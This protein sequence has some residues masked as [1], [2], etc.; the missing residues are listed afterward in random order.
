MLH[1][2][3]IGKKKPAN[4]DIYALSPHVSTQMEVEFKQRWM[5]KRVGDLQAQGMTA[6]AAR[7]RAEQE[8]DTTYKYTNPANGVTK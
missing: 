8:F 3:F 7:A 2:P 4:S 6:E 1:I 5:D